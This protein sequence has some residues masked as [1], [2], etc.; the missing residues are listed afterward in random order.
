VL[1]EQKQKQRHARHKKERPP[2]K[3]TGIVKSEQSPRTKR[4]RSAR[5]LL[6]KQLK[7]AAQ[8]GRR[9][10]RRTLQVEEEGGRN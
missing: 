5:E 10:R 6:P 8:M 2:R 9:H 1:R 7:L 3:G 4:E